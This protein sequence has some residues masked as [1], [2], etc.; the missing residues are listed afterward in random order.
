MNKQPM[1]LR[2]SQ[3]ETTHGTRRTILL[4][5]VVDKGRDNVA[6][7]FDMVNE[8]NLPVPE[9]LD[10]FVVGIIFYAMRLGQN[11]RV[12]GVMSVE[13]LRNLNE[14]QE[15]WTLWKGAHYTKVEII[16][17]D[18]KGG[19][20]TARRD[21]TIAAFSGGVDSIFTLLRHSTGTLGLA[22]YP[23]RRSVL[24]V[25]GFDVP[26][27]EPGKF[28]ALKERTAPL[29]RELNLQ[30]RMIR[31]NLKEVGL[32]DWEDSFL[33]QLAC[34]LHNYS[35]E[36]G[37]ALVGS[38]EPYNALVL[39][40]GSNP[41]TDYL[42][43]GS[44]LRIVHDGAGYSRTQKVET[45]ARNELASKVVKV[46]W[47]GKET[48]KNCGTC[49]KCVRTRLNFL[50]VGVADPGCFD[51]PLDLRRIS[52]IELKN[53]TQAAELRSIVVYAKSKGI[54]D[55]WV[56]ALERRIKEYDSHTKVRRFAS[57]IKKAWK[58]TRE[59]Q[60]HELRKR[61]E[62]KVKAVAEAGKLKC[63]CPLVVPSFFVA[64]M[65]ICGGDLPGV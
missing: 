58:L 30:V 36:F 53:D 39:P 4:S 56:N 47:E 38:S 5:N 26:L 2:L 35:H 13:A 32:Q 7:S 63:Y 64:Q 37:H 33:S 25:H 16:P 3:E 54:N 48:H 1:D 43:S 29:L 42:L 45:I 10:G 46:C 57:L 40:W 50:A 8:R 55:R 31:T 21:D 15:A 22:S 18:V 19:N 27:R 14:F 11:V 49:E 52:D 41:A 51:T 9:I 62:N 17:N 60:W 23:V 65:A 44:A 34:C 12:H 28:Q 59:G 20:T 24:M 61:M 6:I